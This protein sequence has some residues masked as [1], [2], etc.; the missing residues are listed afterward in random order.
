MVID[1][2]IMSAITGARVETLSFNRYVGIGFNFHDLLARFDDQSFRRSFVD[3]L[4]SPLGEV[5]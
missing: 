2:F 1:Q 4:T 3:L 5:L